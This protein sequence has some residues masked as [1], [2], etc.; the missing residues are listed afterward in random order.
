[1]VKEDMVYIYKENAIQPQKRLESCHL[2]QLDGSWGPYAKSKEEERERQI[3]Y[4]LTYMWNLK[5]KTKK[6]Q[7]IKFIGTKK[8]L[9]EGRGL[10]MDEMGE[11]VK[12]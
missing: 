10:G 6:K 9:P 2:W 8:W 11:K 5:N 4:D 12:R 3:P 7:N 1:M